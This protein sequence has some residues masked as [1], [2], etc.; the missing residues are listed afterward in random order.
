MYIVLLICTAVIHVKPAHTTVTLIIC[1][2]SEEVSIT[3][4]SAMFNQLLSYIN[5]ELLKDIYVIKVATMKNT[6]DFF[7]KRKPFRT[8]AKSTL[9]TVSKDE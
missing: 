4:I 2:N 9:F 1:I 7:Y 5:L 8:T 6:D 3:L